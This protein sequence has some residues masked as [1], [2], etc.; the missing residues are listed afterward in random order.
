MIIVMKWLNSSIWL[1]DWTQFRL[2]NGPGSY[3]NEKLHHISLSSR[4]MLGNNLKFCLIKF[5]YLSLIIL[6]RP[7]GRVFANGLENGGSIPGRVIPDSKKWYL[8][9]SCLTLSNIRYISRVKWSNPGKGVV[10]SLT[11]WCSRYWKGSFRVAFDDGCQLY[12]Y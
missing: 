9:P 10:S 6:Y 8:I 1:I 5:N 12:L 11:P 2:D 7:I 3:S 4:D